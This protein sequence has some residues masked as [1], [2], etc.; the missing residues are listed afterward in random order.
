MLIAGICTCLGVGFFP[1]PGTCASVLTCLVIWLCE[2]VHPLALL[3]TLLLGLWSTQHYLKQTK[4]KDPSCV[5]IDEVMGMLVT[6]LGVTL[7]WQKMLIGLCLFR[8]LDITK[9]WLIKRVERLPGA[10]GVM[11]D[12]IL[13]GMCSMFFLQIGDYYV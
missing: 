11:A 8:V 4:T 6:F 2:G 13:A 7:S 1:A 12:D 3:L 5:V 9:P 10:Y